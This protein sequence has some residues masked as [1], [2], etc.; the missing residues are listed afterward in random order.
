MER[1]NKEEF[2]NSVGIIGKRL[3]KMRLYLLY[4]L[5]ISVSVGLLIVPGVSARLIYVAQN[6]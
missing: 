1:I 3:S 2:M 5:C 6:P 4:L